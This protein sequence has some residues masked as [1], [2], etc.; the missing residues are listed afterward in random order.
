M[1][2]YGLSGGQWHQ[3]IAAWSGWLMDGY[4]SISYVLLVPIISVI[5]FPAGFGGFIATI[6]AF[7]VGA[8]ARS[9]GSVYLGAALGDR[10]GRK[11]LLVSL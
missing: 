1:K 7:V 9:V 4:V 3:V 11:R 6:L 2:V 5:L 8:I 10:I